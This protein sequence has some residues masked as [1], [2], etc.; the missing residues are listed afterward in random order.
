MFLFGLGLFAQGNHSVYKL[1][2]MPY[3]KSDASYG[4]QLEWFLSLDAN[5]D[6]KQSNKAVSPFGVHYTFQHYVNNR[7]VLYSIVK[8]HYKHDGSVIIQDFLE[9]NNVASFNEQLPYL[10]NTHEGLVS[11]SEV[12]HNHPVYPKTHYVTQD[13][14]LVFSENDYRYYKD[15]SVHVNVYSINPINSADTAYGGDF[16]DNND[17]SNATLRA[18]QQWFEVYARYDSGKFYLETDY[19]QFKNVSWPPDTSDYS[20]VSDSFDFDR[21]D[22]RFEAANAYF[23]LHNMVEYA[24][25]L[26]YDSILSFLE[27]DVHAF[28]GADNSAFDPLNFTLQ[29]GEGGV[30]DAEDGEVV[31]HELVHAFSEKV[32]PNTT[33]GKQ[34][35]A[36]EEGFCDYVAKAYS[37]TFNDNTSNLIFSWDGHNQFWSGFET[38]TG[39]MYPQDL[40]NQKDG[41][42][43]MWSSVLTCIHDAIGRETTDSLVFEH[44]YYQG[45]NT[46]M[47]EMAQ[48]IMDI[49]SADFGG[50]NYYAL[51][52]CFANGGFREYG[53]SIADLPTE[54]RNVIRN[55]AAFNSGDGELH[56]VLQEPSLISIYNSLGEL[57]A[58]ENT[59][60]L[61]LAPANFAKGLYII[62]LVQNGIKLTFKVVR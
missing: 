15:T 53:A 43:D 25:M 19:L 30:D 11:V 26:G 61:S 46:T 28:G 16:V 1:K 51:H 55:S 58:Q 32:S 3:I 50:R 23:H 41:D 34:R 17:S 33:I 54:N 31:V 24:A 35:E 13:G 4:N 48:A 7:T 21:L 40:L 9:E 6:L 29:F 62:Q 10:A 47:A 18:E 8:L 59:E 45:P 27:V 37:R 56:I 57:V 39:R 52:G 20:Q 12:H 42:R 36:M 22:Q 49:D 60:E 2:E 14:E 38:N 5:E 44:F